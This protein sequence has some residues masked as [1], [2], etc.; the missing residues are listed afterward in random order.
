[1]RNWNLLKVMIHVLTKMYVS[2][3]DPT[4]IH[5]QLKEKKPKDSITTV[6]EPPKAATAVQS[7]SPPEQSTAS[8]AGP[9][10]S[11]VRRSSERVR[12]RR[13]KDASGGNDD[14]GSFE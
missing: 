9:R 14:V 3:L 6:T 8:D 12:G 1:M 2:T 10:S 11:G 4:I 7:Y 13:R 5:Q